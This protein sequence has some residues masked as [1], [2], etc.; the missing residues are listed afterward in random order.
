MNENKQLKVKDLVNIGVFSALYMVVSMIVMLPA[1]VAPVIW[2][3][4]PGI[5]GVICGIFF[6]MLMIKVKKGGTAL[7]LC[8]ITGLLY[9][10]T[11]ECTW[12][13]IASCAVGGVLA[14]VSR[15][16]LGYD[17][18]KGIAVSGGFAAVGLIGSP[19]PMWLFQE[20][21]MKSIIEMGMAEDYVAR[22]QAMTSIT[23]LIGMISFAFIGGVIGIFIG[24]GMMKKHFRK[25]GIV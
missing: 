21:Y 9:F 6:T 25:A 14:E 20:A 18:F 1:G 17:T 12:V 10:A 22:L 24:Y 3:L 7:I 4:W 13:M 8:L 15:K 11:G 2:I 5:A 23:T 16:I 19:L